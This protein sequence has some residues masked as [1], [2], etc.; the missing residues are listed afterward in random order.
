MAGGPS[1]PELAA[2]VSNSGGLGSLGAAYLSPK[3]IEEEIKRIRELT[4]R[5]FA[6]NLFSP[7]GFEPLSGDVESVG[8]WNCG[9]VDIQT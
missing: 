6:V 5:P 3:K 4:D 9:G 1:T 7:Q 8:K 2:A